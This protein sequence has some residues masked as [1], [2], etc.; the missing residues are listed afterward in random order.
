MR[1]M[2]VGRAKQGDVVAAAL[3][4]GGVDVERS[5]ES[6][7]GAADGDEV[8]ELAAALVAFESLLA[9]CGPDALLLV[10]RTNAALAAVLVASKLQ[11]P[12]AALVD[13]SP[14]NGESELNARLIERLA[15]RAVDG[16]ATTIVAA[17]RDLIAA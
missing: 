5:P 13:A 2:I 12:V 7:P 4:A 1:I 8:R 3:E 11:I 10:S 16:D 6:S 9:D 15:D 14:G 17:L